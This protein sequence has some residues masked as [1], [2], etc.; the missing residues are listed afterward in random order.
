MAVPKASKMQRRLAGE[1]KV[2]DRFKPLSR[3]EQAEQEAE[4]AA[5]ANP[6][7]VIF[8]SRDDV[9][10]HKF[11]AA[12]DVL[13]SISDTGVSPPALS[14][15]PKDMVAIDFHD[16]VDVQGERQ[17]HHWITQEQALQVA[18]FVQ[19]HT[20]VRN[21][22]VHCNYGESRSKGVAMAI[23]HHAEEPKRSVFHTNRG[24][25]VPYHENGDVGNSRA[26]HLVADMLYH[27]SEQA[28]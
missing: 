9:M 6:H 16:W 8:M 15:A 17:G 14:S 24:S 26:Y 4:K 20:D 23:H 3:R 22:I 21:I 18:Q 10:S 19:K 25:I 7:R 11:N 5:W 1:P 13:I 27:C 12:E 2:P 28:A